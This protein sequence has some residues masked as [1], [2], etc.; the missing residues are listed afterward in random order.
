MKTCRLCSSNDIK[1]IH[2]GT[3]DRKDIDVLKCSGCG[4][5]FLSKIET[6]DDFYASGD[7]RL[8]IDFAKWRKVTQVDDKRRFKYFKDSLKGKSVLD[9][10][11][12]NG[13]FLALARNAGTGKVAGVEHDKEA[14]RILKESGIECY[15]DIADAPPRRLMAS[16]PCFM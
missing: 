9:F 10:G 16:F 11:C 12:G 1:R 6:N 7:M 15:Q 2:R 4:L 13:G 3:R 8:G 5:V 14:F